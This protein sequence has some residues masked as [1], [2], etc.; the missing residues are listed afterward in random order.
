MEDLGLG[1][2][3]ASACEESDDNESRFGLMFL[4]EF[5]YRL[6]GLVQI[7]GCQMVTMFCF[8]MI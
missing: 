8:T 4:S 1:G 5:W 6:T 2:K 7:I 3:V